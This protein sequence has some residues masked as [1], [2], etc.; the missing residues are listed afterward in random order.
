MTRRLDRIPAALGALVRA[1]RLDLGLTQ[2]ACAELAGMHRVNW[3]ALERGRRGIPALPLLL[4][5]CDVLSLD[6]SRL[7]ACLDAASR[8]DANARAA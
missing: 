3:C 1:R 6:A 5:I 2:A 7:M 4:R 8:P